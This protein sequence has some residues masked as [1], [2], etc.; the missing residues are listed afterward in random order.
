MLVG[1]ALGAAPLQEGVEGVGRRG[2]RASLVRVCDRPAPA[3]ARGV[4][5]FAD[6]AARSLEEKKFRA[7]TVARQW[8]EQGKLPPAR[9]HIRAQRYAV[10]LFLAHWHHVAY[11]VRYGAPPPKPYIIEHD[12]AHT[13]FKAPPNWPMS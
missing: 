11:E 13:H 6:Q 5:Q 3:G 2:G 7:D 8:Y 4:G 10:K 12:A 9:I 1:G